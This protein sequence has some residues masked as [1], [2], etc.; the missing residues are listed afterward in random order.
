MYNLISAE[1]YRC[2][3]NKL[4][5][6]CVIAS[7]ISGVVYGCNVCIIQ[8]FDD[9]Y[10]VPLF[11]ILAAFI[12]L[13]IGRE[14]G[15]GTIRNKIISGKSKKT[16]MLS[17]I[18]ISILVSVIFTLVYLIP[19]SL[20]SMN[21][22]SKIP[23]SVLIWT[24]LGFFL[25]NI[26]WSSIFSFFSSLI[27]TKEIAAIINI[28]MVIIIMFGS[29]QIEHTIGQPEFLE[30]EEAESVKMTADEVK[31]LKDG[32]FDGS[33]SFDTND[34]G[35][36]I[37]YKDIIVGNSKEPNPSYLGKQVN[38]ALKAIDYTLPH[39]QIN[40]YMSSLTYYADEDTHNV[41]YDVIKLFPLY[42]LMLMLVFSAIG[43][44]TFRNKDL[45]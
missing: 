31:Q 11:V 27:T 23:T 7:L 40:F 42:S 33:Y 8:A 4:F 18:C 41:E 37:Y 29:Y 1:I 13:S 35:V 24:L 22:I 15:D 20:I 17:R 34:E 10:I 3:H 25:L 16:I 28:A 14:Y 2:K 43:I 5:W 30:V 19:C 32:T 9:M 12:S 39:G 45:K 38:T 26:A 6:F 44:A 21:V 36:V